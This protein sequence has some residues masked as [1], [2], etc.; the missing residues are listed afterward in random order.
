[1]F[2]FVHL[3]IDFYPA[4]ATIFTSKPISI[5][6]HFDFLITKVWLTSSKPFDFFQDNDAYHAGVSVPA[7]HS[8][9]E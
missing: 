5:A 1:M 8:S 2:I 7:I 9:N 6:I 3:P 4:Y